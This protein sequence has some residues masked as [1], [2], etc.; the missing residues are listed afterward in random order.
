MEAGLA[1]VV[2]VVV[3]VVVSSFLV[4]RTEIWEM[5]SSR[6]SEG[7]ASS[8]SWVMVTVGFFFLT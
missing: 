6:F 7:A 8:R 1:A 5:R 4:L 3:V 2:V